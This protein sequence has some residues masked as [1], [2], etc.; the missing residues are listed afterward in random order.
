MC[1]WSEASHNDLL[2]L[3]YVVGLVSDYQTAESL[4]RW[5]KP[6]IYC[7][8]LHVLHGYWITLCLPILWYNGFNLPR[9]NK[10]KKMEKNA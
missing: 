3:C 10:Q 7:Q 1:L 5:R 8:S 9:Y 6:P 4:A 2:L